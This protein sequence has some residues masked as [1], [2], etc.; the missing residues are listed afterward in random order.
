MRGT[1][2]IYHAYIRD[3]DANNTDPDWELLDN[4]NPAS[5]VSI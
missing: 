3:L 4:D 1:L 5:V 2:E